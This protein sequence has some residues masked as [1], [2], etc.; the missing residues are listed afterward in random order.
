MDILCEHR[1]KWFNPH[2]GN[3][4]LNRNLAIV[5]HLKSF[6]WFLYDGNIC[7]KCFYQGEMQLKLV[8]GTMAEISQE[9]GYLI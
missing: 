2:K 5:L 4:L 6:F 3:I 9:Q 1:D 7:L 8:T